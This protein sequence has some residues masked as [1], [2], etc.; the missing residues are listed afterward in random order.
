MTCCAYL[1]AGSNSLELTG[2]ADR[3]CRDNR[4]CAGDPN[5]GS[6]GLFLRFRRLKNTSVTSL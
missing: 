5:V 4:R 1:G 3:V 2:M 6:R